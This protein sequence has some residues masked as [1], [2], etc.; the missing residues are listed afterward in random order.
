METISGNTDLGLQNRQMSNS[1]F[2]FTLN[3]S[4]EDQMCRH[5]HECDA[6]FYP[7]LSSRTDL[8]EYVKKLEERAAR[9]EAWSDGKLIALLAVYANDPGSDTAFISN[10]SVSPGFQNNGLASILLQQCISHLKDRKFSSIKLE[11]HQDSIFALKLYS[12][13]GFTTAL[14]KGEVLQL[15][16]NI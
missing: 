14:K 11:V 16:A 13:F 9:F 10:V 5:L 3:A 2:L 7:S 4:G 6:Y 1:K 12:K 15:E 8:Q